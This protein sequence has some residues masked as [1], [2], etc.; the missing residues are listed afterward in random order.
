MTF[1]IA[2]TTALKNRAFW[3]TY[4]ASPYLITPWI[5]GYAANEIIAP[6]GIGYRWGF[7]FCHHNAHHQCSLMGLVVL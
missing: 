4:A 1:F 5:Y 3:I 6:G 2:D 7:W